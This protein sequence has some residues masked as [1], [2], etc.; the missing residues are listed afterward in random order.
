MP[1]S[2][3][4][5]PEYITSSECLLFG[6]AVREPP[7]SWDKGELEHTQQHGS[8]ESG[9]PEPKGGSIGRALRSLRCPPHTLCNF[10]GVVLFCDSK[11]V[12]SR[13]HGNMSQLVKCVP[14]GQKRVA[15]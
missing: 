6:R 7:V 2:P 9:D 11:L 5:A 13:C 14:F 4:K 12:K 10:R 15:F 3:G 8:L 1:L